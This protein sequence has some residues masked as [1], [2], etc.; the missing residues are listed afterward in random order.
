MTDERIK[1]A[2]DAWNVLSDATTI[3]MSMDWIL[4]DSKISRSFNCYD[5]YTD[6]TGE[7]WHLNVD[8]IISCIVARYNGDKE[9]TLQSHI[10]IVDPDTGDWDG[11]DYDVSSFRVCDHCGKIMREGWYLNGEYACSEGCAIHLYGGD[12][13]QF[14]KDLDDEESESSSTECYWTRWY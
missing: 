5:H 7:Y 11:E 4:H 9:L 14:K 6:N 8:N 10:E 2:I 1:E 13:E 3:S 12:E